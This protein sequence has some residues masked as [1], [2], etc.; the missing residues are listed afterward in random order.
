MIKKVF[1]FIAISSILVAC[2]EKATETVS[3]S[4]FAEKAKT[5]VEKIKGL[6]KK[7]DPTNIDTFMQINDSI[8]LQQTL[9]DSAIAEVYKSVKD[10]MF[11]EFTQSKNVEKIKILKVWVTG[12]KFNELQIQASVQAVD[13]S[14]FMGPYTSATMIDK[15]GKRIEVGGG[16]G[17]PA[18]EKLVAGQ[19][20]IFNGTIDNLHLL[21]ELKSLNFDEAIKKW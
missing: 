7:L 8:A 1:V 21:G 3:L 18:T 2:N 19:T 12:A 6:E 15:T 10:T 13:N 20:Y 14:S 11:L 17:G 5:F 9:A 16:I 4:L